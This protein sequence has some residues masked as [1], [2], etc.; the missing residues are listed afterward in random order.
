[1]L[2]IENGNREAIGTII[3]AVIVPFSQL[4]EGPPDFFEQVRCIL[5]TYKELNDK[6]L[7]DI[8]LPK[9]FEIVTSEQFSPLRTQFLNAM[10]MQCVITPLNKLAGNQAFFK[11]LRDIHLNYQ[12]LDALFP[13]AYEFMGSK[14]FFDFKAT[15]FNIVARDTIMIPLSTLVGEQNFF[16]QI[17]RHKPKY[18][19]VKDDHMFDVLLSEAY[20]IVISKEFSSIKARALHPSFSK[21]SGSPIQQR[22]TAS[23]TVS[24]NNHYQNKISHLQTLF[25]TLQ[26]G[27]STCD[28]FSNRQHNASNLQKEYKLQQW[29]SSFQFEIHLSQKKL[30]EIQDIITSTLPK[31]TDLYLKAYELKTMC[32]QLLLEAQEL[33]TFNT[34][35][36]IPALISRF[37]N[38]FDPEF[39][40]A[41]HS[42]VLMFA[43]SDIRIHAEH[44][45][46]NQLLRYRPV[47][48]LTLSLL[49]FPLNVDYAQGLHWMANKPRVDQLELYDNKESREREFLLHESQENNM[50]QERKAINEAQDIA[51]HNPENPQAILAKTEDSFCCNDKCSLM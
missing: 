17:R 16:K 7:F 11:T 29:V 3:S 23:T 36:I 37:L 34:V 14:H 38:D 44:F 42:Q 46:S 50:E 48:S 4:L 31:K 25:F 32:Q 12:T 20:S 6:Q 8:L 27:E 47:P 41:L 2:T 28:L 18:K 45:I 30:T 10:A 43:N 49:P 40:Q 19:T 26:Q 33:I 39:I 1:M 21:S 15:L 35:H 22:R 24:E 13:V 9:A 51:E 5:P